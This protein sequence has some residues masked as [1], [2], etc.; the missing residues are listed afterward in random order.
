[1]ENIGII[2]I[3]CRFPGAN[4]PEAFWNLLHDGI[5]AITEIP[6]NRWNVDAFYSEKSGIP[7]KMN[8]R[9]GGFL[10]HPDEFDPSFFG[11]SP[12]EAQYI[13]PQQRLVLEVAWEALEH[14]G[15]AP[16]RLANTATGVF[17]GVTNADYH[18]MLY[19]D[20]SAINGYC[21]TGTSFSIVANR[22]S[23]LLD[24]RGPSITIDTACSSSLVAL[25]YAC[26]SLQSGE[27]DL[28]IVGGVNV[29]LTPEMHITFS[30]A[31][32][33]AADGRCKA[34][35]AAADGYSRSEGCGVVIL[36]R[37]SDAINSKD[38]VLAV[39]RGSAVN[40]DG[41]SNGITA[42]N[43]FAQQLVIRKALESA[44]V[45]PDQVSYVEA[46]G[47]GTPLGDP[48]EIKS[49]K[50]VLMANRSP[51]QRCW[52]GSVKTNLGHLEAAAGIAGLIK[53]VLSLQH[54][55]I[56]AHLHLKQLNPYISLQDTPFRIP[57][58]RQDWTVE[59]QQR[60]TG[61][62]AFG[63][64]GTNCHVILK[65]FLSSSTLPCPIQRPVH[66]LTLS[67][68]N[69]QALKQLAQRYIDFF[70]AHPEASL[71]D[72]CSTTN[73][74]R[75]HFDCRLAMPAQSNTQVQATLS[76]F[77]N[78]Q[79]TSNLITNK[80]SQNKEP[81]IVFLFTGQ[82]AQYQG[83]GAQLYETQSVFREA[84]EQCD[85]ILSAYLD[86]SLTDILF[87]R[88]DSSLLE[89]PVYAQP[90]LF[91]IEY[92]ITKL[93]QSW[94]IEPAAVIGHSLG[95]YVAAC[96]TGVF[97]LEDGLKLIME[98]SQLVQSLPNN[99]EMAVVFA[100]EATVRRIIQD[101]APTISIAA[102]NAPKNTVVSGFCQD[103]SKLTTHLAEQGIH[104]RKLTVSHAFHSNLLEPILPMFEEKASQI[105]SQAPRL[106]FASTLT[107]EFMPS[108]FVPDAK[109]WRNQT[110]ETVRFM[111]GLNALLQQ[112][113]NIFLEV[114]PKPV[115]SNLG[116]SFQAGANITWLPSLAQGKDDW[117]VLMESLSALYVSG[118]SI[119][120]EGLNLD[121]ATQRIPLPTYPFQRTS[122]LVQRKQETPDYLNAEFTASKTSMDTSSHT[123]QHAEIISNLR[124]ITAELLQLD[125]SQVDI[126]ASLLDL[127]ADSLVLIEAVHRVE[128]A[129]KVKVAIHQL[130][131]ELATL[132]ALALYIQEQLSSKA[133]ASSEVLESGD[134]F[135]VQAIASVS[136]ISSASE[137]FRN[138][139]P[140]LEE[141]ILKQLQVML[142]QLQIL[143]GKK[144]DKLDVI[145]YPLSDSQKRFARLAKLGY[146]GKQAG[147]MGCAIRI[148]RE[149]NSSLL[150]K[151][152]K[153]VLIRHEC[154]SNVIDINGERQRKGKFSEASFIE[155]DLL[156][157]PDFTLEAVLAQQG[158]YEFDLMN[159]PPIIL[160]VIR[161]RNSECYL[162]LNAHH[163][164]GDGWSF[165]LL[166]GELFNLYQAYEEDK[167][168]VLSAPSSY[169]EY[170]M[171]ES[172]YLSELA[173]QYW[174]K[175]HSE[176]QPE[177]LLSVI[178]GS[179]PPF[180]GKRLL[181][182]IT[183]ESIKNKLKRL[184]MRLRCTTFILL[185]VL[186]Q[187]YLCETYEKESFTV[188][189]PTANRQFSG[190]DALVGCCV[191][192]MPIV[193][194]CRAENNSPEAFSRTVKESLLDAFAN[195]N[196][197]YSQ[198]FSAIAQLNPPE[199]QPVQITFNLEPQLALSSE[200][201]KAASFLLL[202][203][204]YVEF[205]LMLNILEQDDE[206][207]L[208]FDYQ[209]RY[210]TE[211]QATEFLEGFALMIK[212]LVLTPEEEPFNWN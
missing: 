24:L 131:E 134:D 57:V 54:K 1:M 103:M 163:F 94:G 76:A 143:Q 198:W 69:E 71:V 124:L 105:S 42:P 184:A 92:A 73:Q 2:G 91:A 95:E 9:S 55:Q 122:Y 114:G 44:N 23:Y 155:I 160:S 156:A 99:G 170:V 43:G 14:A 93:W 166:V 202:P 84:I 175:Q 58:E 61:I 11:I 186:F 31:G 157:Y 209:M 98:R 115:L 4:S 154:L 107:G 190:G 158:N 177:M 193:C 46:H 179:I 101:H 148:N 153:E 40:Q 86:R 85:T 195:Q 34:F 127:G 53:V 51:N 79:Q 173:L 113:Y 121:Y 17:I 159:G 211:T 110:R 180:T 111:D 21:G 167:A 89:Q 130:F 62:S 6:R 106:P 104:T 45:S 70:A 68:K 185:F 168:I 188:A 181:H 22:L 15:I 132:S 25:H 82:G 212:T 204:R 66:L 119:N 199:Y 174:V 16:D 129:Y 151:A 59:S 49:L 72:V 172:N 196:F 37:L 81:Q 10:Q 90:A 125:I 171:N 67:A 27:S 149:I 112:G 97:S 133:I 12:R 116:R 117:D 191:N 205:P 74:G 200:S 80:V 29:I 30:Q 20:L 28:C 77:V 33:M 47:T 207:Y 65:E 78:E 7:G 137:E 8:T 183:V 120:W 197:S 123:S 169:S 108:G 201:L 164:V 144:K 141:I 35:D 192:L 96:I 36:R 100:D 64:G 39:I 48:I 150:K 142:E 165:S 135:D 140:V 161:G 187:I 26:Q 19:K 88:S 13:D 32:M 145:W 194:S 139:E 182:V 50:A 206:L 138:A 162:S 176:K 189:V 128:N 18:R 52:I 102:I 126:H 63:F 146:E 87:S 152:W 147:N 3:G 56:P 5:D 60:I 208:K 83:M 109:Y 178:D 41:R 118:A 136:H 38:N 210:F 203:V 75:S